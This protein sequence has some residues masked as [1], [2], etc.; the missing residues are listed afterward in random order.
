V[1][2]TTEKFQVVGPVVF[3]ISVL[4]VYR[5]RYMPCNGMNSTPTT[6]L[7]FAPRSLK[8]PAAHVAGNS[9]VTP[10]SRNLA[11]EP[12]FNIPQ[13]IKLKAALRRAEP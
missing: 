13:V 1:A 12:S 11:P 4:V 5:E 3:R 8:E 7:T 6:L 2:P 9:A 10:P